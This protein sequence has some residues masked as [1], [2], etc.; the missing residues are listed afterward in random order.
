MPP[1][2]RDILDQAHASLA[3]DNAIQAMHA[4]SQA[5]RDRRTS[6]GEAE[7]DELMRDAR[8]HPL[9]ALLREDPLTDRARAR[10]RGYPGDAVAMDFM[11]AGMPSAIRQTTS[12]L[13]RAV[14]AYTAGCSA[15]AV[16]VRQ[17]RNTL[18]LAID[19]VASS[20]SGARVMAAGC[21]HLREARLSRAV[22]SGTL[23][24]LVA[25]DGDR[26]HLRVV[27][28]EFGPATKVKTV[29]AGVAE[30]AAGKLQ[31]GGFDLVYSA[32][33]FERLD[34]GEARAVT[35]ALLHT[36]RPGGRLLI[37]NFVDG[38]LA[39]EL[40]QAFMDWKLACRDETQLLGLAGE[41]SQRAR[42]GARAW[43]DA[44]GCLA[45]LEIRRPGG[46]D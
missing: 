33:L 7:W 8:E 4:L 14:F 23:G 40:M 2:L 26:E 6:L 42:M 35:A 21:G 28:R 5:L 39:H 31:L 16:A 12:R 36:L 46:A 24:E 19:E 32:G 45:W 15:A 44:T 29:F 43:R 3:P 9:A 25:L 20:V 10:P 34:D 17:R 11:Y 38:F 37:S 41:V 1:D 18:S 22:T 13:G 27:S 30:V